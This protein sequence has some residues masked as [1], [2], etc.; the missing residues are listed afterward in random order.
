MTI[1]LNR[2][3]EILDKCP[4]SAVK[5]LRRWNQ[6]SRYS[7]W[8]MMS[9]TFFVQSAG[10]DWR[11]LKNE[12]NLSIIPQDFSFFLK[13]L[14]I[15]YTVIVVFCNFSHCVTSGM[16]SEH[17]RNSLWPNGRLCSGQHI[18]SLNPDIMSHGMIYDFLIESTIIKNSH[19][20]S[21]F[22]E[23]VILQSFGET[24]SLQRFLS[25]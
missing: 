23:K 9:L 2:K 11:F 24:F 1:W 21:L 17:Q 19:T 5:I 22:L 4:S 16:M 20:F 7:K 8:F 15:L 14:S 12:S 6:Y 18:L 3:Q 25:H 13:F 10:N